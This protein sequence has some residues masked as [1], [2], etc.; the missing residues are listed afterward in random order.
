MNTA[1]GIPTIQGSDDNYITVLYM[2][3]NLFNLLYVYILFLC[4]YSEVYGV[5]LTN[6][7]VKRKFHS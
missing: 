7:R 1:T 5:I 6:Y 4:L 2:L 3:T